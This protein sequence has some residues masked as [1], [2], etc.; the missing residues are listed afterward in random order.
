M[1]LFDKA[2]GASA[3]AGVR[4]MPQEMAGKGL[5]LRAAKLEGKAAGED[6]K[7]ACI[8]RVMHL[9][10]QASVQYTALSLIKAYYPFS[11][12]I[13]LKLG[14]AFYESH[15]SIGL[16]TSSHRFPV[17]LIQ[18]ESLEKPLRLGKAASVG[19]DAGQAEEVAWSFPLDDEKP[20]TSVLILVLAPEPS[21]KL[22]TLFHV[23]TACR[24]RLIIGG[25]SSK[26]RGTIKTFLSS[27]AMPCL[28]LILER[29]GVAPA[30]ISSFE[31]EAKKASGEL[32][33]VYPLQANRMLVSIKQEHDSE[34][35][36]HRLSKTLS[37]S[38]I[39]KSLVQNVDSAYDLVQSV[40]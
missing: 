5:L 18:K 28:L 13:L 27:L 31:E 26:E 21:Y 8:E 25:S 32:A 34:L 36:A 39:V 14:G 22:D 35:I 9:P 30:P 1:G 4:S 7:V 17:E 33:S 20:S 11:A 29:Q 2:L 3:N 19:I 6:F 12:G 16:E 40:M 37:S 24:S 23:I 10:L 38:I 15:S